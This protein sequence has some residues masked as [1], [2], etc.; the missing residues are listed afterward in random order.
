MIVHDSQPESVK[1]EPEARPSS[2]QQDEPVTAPVS[3]T[4]KAK[5]TQFRLGVGRPVI[6]GGAG[7]RDVTKVASGAKGKRSQSRSA[8]HPTEPTI[9]EEG[10]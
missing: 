7:A 3:R 2:I 10:Q 9:E 5:D 1:L 8:A 6:A 4:R